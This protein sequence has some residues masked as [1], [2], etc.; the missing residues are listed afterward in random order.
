MQKLVLLISIRKVSD[1]IIKSDKYV[2]AKLLF[3]RLLDDNLTIAILS[4]KV[5][6][7][8]NFLAN[9]LLNN[10]ILSSQNIIINL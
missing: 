4:M 1:K 3:D 6:L 2:V 8:D 7:I 10:D 5:H 9:L